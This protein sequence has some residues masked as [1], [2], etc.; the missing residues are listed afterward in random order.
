MI[1]AIPSPPISE[2]SLG[3]LT[4]HFY[5]LMILT[6]ILVAWKV[7]DKRYTAKGGPADFALDVTVPMV[8]VGILGARLYHV[9]T[10]PDAY[11]GPDGDPMK[12]FRIWEG[13]LGIW[14][15]I[16]AG[17]LAAWVYMRAKKMR[18]DAIADS[19][20]P[21]LL[22]AQGIGRLGNY[23]NQELFG[24]PTTAPW[25]LAIDDAH[26]PSG[27]ES[28]TLFHPTFLY[29]LLWCFAGAGLLFW[30]DR[31]FKLN[32]GQAFWAYVLIYTAGRAVIET[33]RIDDAQIIAGLRL[34]VWT[35]MIVFTF[36]AIMFVWRRRV[37]RHTVA[38]EIY[39]DDHPALHPTGE[40]ETDGSADGN[41]TSTES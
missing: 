32:R 25:G 13:G 21:G 38:S 28:G 5:A 8:L 17:G 9:I 27:F 36:A 12:A 14:G 37:A 30:L 18:I 39:Y 40:T 24:G 3:P 23:F 16:A 22:L 10:S 15:A 19:V 20:A 2:I 34:N 41:E 33:V 6:G 7:M 1:T 11:F 35:A 31:R 29:E 26:L 4:I